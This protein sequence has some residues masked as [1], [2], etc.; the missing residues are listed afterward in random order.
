MAFPL[1]FDK[2]TNQGYPPLT[3]NQQRTPATIIPIHPSL[4]GLY[5]RPLLALPTLAVPFLCFFVIKSTSHFSSRPHSRPCSSHFIPLSHYSRFSCISGVGISIFRLLGFLACFLFFSTYGVL[6]HSPSPRLLLPSFFPSF[7]L[8]PCHHPFHL[9][10]I[11]TY[12]MT[13]LNFELI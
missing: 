1:Y 5:S 13:D 7:L 3:D 11:H 4:P 10:S 9:S 2:Q 12:V 6:T 8:L